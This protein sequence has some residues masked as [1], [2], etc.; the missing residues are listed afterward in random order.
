VDDELER[1][2]LLV[3][4]HE[5]HVGEAL[6][7]SES[8]APWESALGPFE[9]A[10]RELVSAICDHAFD[11][12]GELPFGYAQIVDQHRSAVVAAEIV[13]ALQVW[14]PIADVLIIEPIDHVLAQDQVWQLD[15]RAAPDQSGW[16]Q[17]RLLDGGSIFAPPDG[18]HDLLSKPR[19]MGPQA[20]ERLD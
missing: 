13:H 9:R 4:L 19:E 6:G 5:L 2:E 3:L 8:G 1:I 7:L 14:L 16:N 11:G 20:D 10:R 17:V 15:T 12:P 18:R